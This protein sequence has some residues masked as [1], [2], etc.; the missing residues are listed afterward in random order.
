LIETMFQGLGTL[1]HRVLAMAQLSKLLALL[2]VQQFPTIQAIEVGETLVRLGQ[3]LAEALELR[4]QPRVV[5]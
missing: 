4:L 5:A 1:A 3:H 2:R